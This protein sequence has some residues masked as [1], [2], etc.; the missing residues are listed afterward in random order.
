[1]RRYTAASDGQLP[2]DIAQLAPLL[3]APA[4][5]EI[6]ARYELVPP[7]KLGE[8]A[9]R[10]VRE[11]ATS[12]LIL[13]VGL[14]GWDMSNNSD[15]PA[16]FGESN[17]SALD[18]AAR[19]LGSALGDDAA[20]QSKQAATMSALAAGLEGAMK[21][22]GPDFGEEMKRAAAAFLAAYPNEAVTNVAQI[23]PFVSDPEQFVAAF[24][25]VFAQLDYARE[26]EGQP[27]A[28]PEQLQ[29]YLNRPFSAADAFRTM[30]LKQSGDNFNLNLDLPGSSPGKP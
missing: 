27:P 11:K 13:S 21:N 23:L 15:L 1:M 28:T 17:A 16:A 19:A 18:R 10:L 8:P 7:G 20:D 14:N 5:A 26:H 30:K 3:V 25:P 29:S 24:R 12:D 4:D 9:E 6:L 2:T 22:V